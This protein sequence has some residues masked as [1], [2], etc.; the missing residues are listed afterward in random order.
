MKQFTEMDLQGAVACAKS[1]NQA[2]HLFNV[3]PYSRK[4]SKC[5][6]KK[7]TAGHLIDHNIGRLVQTAKSLGVR[8]IKVDRQGT[9][10]QHIDLCGKPLERA[11]LICEEESG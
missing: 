6:Q 2:L 5:F 7:K 8:V 11:I 3:I 1:G 4:A 9:D 10:K